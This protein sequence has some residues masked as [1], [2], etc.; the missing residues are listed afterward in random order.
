MWRWVERTLVY[1]SYDR[2]ALEARI[3]SLHQ[4]LESRGYAVSSNKYAMML[5][6]WHGERKTRLALVPQ[7]SSWVWQDGFCT[8]AGDDETVADTIGRTLHGAPSITY[9][10]GPVL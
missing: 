10:P 8:I 7:G 9:R 4:V 1:M 5:N 6:V 3:K 2:E